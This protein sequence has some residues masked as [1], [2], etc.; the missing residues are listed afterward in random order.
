MKAITVRRPPPL[1]VA[2]LV[3]SISFATAGALAGSDPDDPP[4]PPPDIGPGLVPTPVVLAHGHKRHPV[5]TAPVA[6]PQYAT[7]PLPDVRRS[8]LAEE[9]KKVKTKRD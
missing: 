6:P 2:I 1:A 8:V 3:L 4:A 9:K 7:Q 5:F